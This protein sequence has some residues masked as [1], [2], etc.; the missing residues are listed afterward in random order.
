[1]IDTKSLTTVA[2]AAAVAAALAFA[3]RDSLK[4][5][6]V[7][8]PIP[9]EVRVGPPAKPAPDLP[10]LVELPGGGTRDLSKPPGDKLL[11]VHFWAT[12]CAPCVEEF[13]GVVAFWKQFRSNPKVELLT[14]SVD[15]GWP[16]VEGW[17]KKSGAAGI[18]VAL[19]P[20]RL[21]AKAFG[22]EKFP[23]TYVIT[24]DGTVLER[25]EGAI[26]WNAPG[27][28]QQITD[29]AAVASKPQRR[30]APKG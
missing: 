2:V 8:R 1:M 17:L 20:K 16:A 13:P 25:Y 4:A 11:V 5:P 19:D 10:K 3:A 28:R 24:A 26:D 23:E 27:F 6:V 7:V 14:V 21:T 9:N 12:W 18:P 22:T 15:E 29:F 30:K